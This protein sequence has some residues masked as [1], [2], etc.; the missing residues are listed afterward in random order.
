MSEEP[1]RLSVNLNK[2]TADALKEIAQSRGISITE[3]VRRSLNVYFYLLEQHDKGRTIETCNSRGK[4]RR[5]LI[6]LL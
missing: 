1:V 6:F 4:R 5:E 3:A 2:D